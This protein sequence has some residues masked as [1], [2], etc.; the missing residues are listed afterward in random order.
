MPPLK[1]CHGLILAGF[2]LWNV[3]PYAISHLAVLTKV[4]ADHCL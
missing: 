4:I 3:T 1:D 2:R